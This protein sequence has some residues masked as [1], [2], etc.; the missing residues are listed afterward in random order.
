[1][2]FLSRRLSSARSATHSFSA[3]ASRRIVSGGSADRIARQAALPGF[4]ELLRPCVIQTLGDAFLTAQLCNA[5]I[6]AQAVQHDPDLV[7]R[8][9]VP[10]G[11]PST[12]MH[13]RFADIIYMITIQ[14]RWRFV[15]LNPPVLATMIA[16]GIVYPLTAFAGSSAAS[17]SC[18]AITAADYP[19]KK[20][21]VATHTD[22]TRSHYQERIAEFT[23]SPLVCGEV[24]MLGDS[25]TERYNWSGSLDT[26]QIVRNR[27][28]AGDTS[29]GVLV[30]LD[31]IAA[32]RPHAVFLLIGTND[33][34]SNNSPK[35][36]VANIEKIIRAL[37]TDNPRLPIFLETVFP[38]RSEPA[39]NGKVKSIN[40]LLAN[41]ASTAKVT[42][43]DTYGVL[44]DERGLLR[45]QYTDDG[46][47]LTSAGYKAWVGLLNTNL[48]GARL[49]SPPTS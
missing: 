39:R 1:M 28:I 10:S 49:A 27:G 45:S 29:D 7:F 3:L 24:V 16:L 34:W 4:H 19:A 37:R 40:A 42:L 31:E 25:L 48:R 30:R 41:L 8:R 13:L 20:V 17:G 12:P 15:V 9:E 44:V 2:L 47:H 33:I 36:T 35:K 18:R 11:R 14:I 32:S 6:A 23:Q 22:W 38:L 21:R 26:S 5:V 43:V 46:V